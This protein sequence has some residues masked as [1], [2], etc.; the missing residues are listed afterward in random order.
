VVNQ[1]YIIVK[2]QYD[3]HLTFSSSTFVQRVLT[4][5][6]LLRKINCPNDP[7]FSDTALCVYSVNKIFVFCQLKVTVIPRRPAVLVWCTKSRRR[8]LYRV[9][10]MQRNSNNISR[11]NA[12]IAK[13][14]D[15]VAP[16]NRMARCN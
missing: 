11:Q 16:R 7:A 5:V 10:F 13:K 12:V 4:F 1:G 2:I 6:I 15:F 9:Q 14:S 8:R 3:R